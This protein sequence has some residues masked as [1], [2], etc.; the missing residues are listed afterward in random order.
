MG[1]GG[2]GSWR[3]ARQRLDHPP[4]PCTHPPSLSTI[5]AVVS[6]ISQMAVV[7]LTEMTSDLYVK[8]VAL[9]FFQQISG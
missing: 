6:Q 5:W 1:G 3:E 7:F 9:T 2:A 8:N 4:S